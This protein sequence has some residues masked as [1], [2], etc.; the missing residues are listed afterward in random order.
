MRALPFVLL[1]TVAGASAA[2]NLIPFEGQRDRSPFM[3]QGP[4]IVA[5]PVALAIA[6]FDADQDGV[7]TRAELNAGA[8]RSFASVAKGAAD[9]GYIGYADW[10]LKWLGDAN[11]LPS[12]FEVDTDRNNR[13]TA[14]ELTAALTD[15][16]NRFDKD[17]DSRLT[18]AELVTIRATMFGNDRPGGPDGKS[19]KGE[20]GRRPPRQ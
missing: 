12:P 4:T 8:T 5:E 11:A 15:A 7:V 18:R 20:K 14:A 9:I 16:F 13:I 6:A 1:L 2:Q 19:G 17:K 3:R 10:A